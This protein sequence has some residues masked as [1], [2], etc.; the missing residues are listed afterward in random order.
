M[1]QPVE[2]LAKLS[3]GLQQLTLAP[4][5]IIIQHLLDGIIQTMGG[6]LLPPPGGPVFQ[7][8]AGQVRALEVLPVKDF[9]KRGRIQSVH[10]RFP[11]KKG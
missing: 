5:D 8:M 11:G 6:S 9:L 3:L 4:V 10:Q 2:A 1:V 7:N